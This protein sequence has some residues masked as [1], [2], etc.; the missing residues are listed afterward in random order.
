MTLLAARQRARR[1]A[2]DMCSA[3]KTSGAKTRGPLL[4]ALIINGDTISGDAAWNGYVSRV[5]TVA[6]RNSN[7]FSIARA[8]P[9]PLPASGNA[10]PLYLTENIVSHSLAL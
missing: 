4:N 1:A 2:R 3:G 6:F 7:R 10:P 9:L 5:G 8:A